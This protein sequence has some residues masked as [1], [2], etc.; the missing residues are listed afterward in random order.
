MIDLYLPIDPAELPSAQQKGVMIQYGHPVFYEKAK[1]KKARSLILTTLLNLH[2][3]ERLACDAYS[4]TIEYV[5]RPKTLRKRDYG[6]RKTTR[7]DID[8]LTKLVLDAITDSH[9][10]FL[11]DGAV[12]TLILRKRNAKEFEEAF[13][14]ITIEEDVDEFELV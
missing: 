8:N 2:N 14:H 9:I 3:G 6:K 1:V 11:D 12:S 5:Y 7:P 10:A 4:V 13:V